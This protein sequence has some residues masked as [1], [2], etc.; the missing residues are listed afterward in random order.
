MDTGS[1][2]NTDLPPGVHV[3][4]CREAGQEQYDVE[5]RIEKPGTLSM[6]WSV[7]RLLASRLSDAAARAESYYTYD[8][9][10][11]CLVEYFDWAVRELKG[12]PQVADESPAPTTH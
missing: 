9:L 1:E 10:N 3:V 11:G 12:T 6:E 4:L 2:M 5:L 7:A 8:F